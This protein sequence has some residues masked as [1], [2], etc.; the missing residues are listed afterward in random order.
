ML[1]CARDMTEVLF[2]KLHSWLHWA[3][4]EARVIEQIKRLR[5]EGLSITRLVDVGCGPGF[6]YRGARQAE[7]EYIGI[8]PDVKNIEAAR[9]HNP[10][11]QFLF[12]GAESL[13]IPIKASD[14]VLLNGVAHHL[15]DTTFNAFFREVVSCGRLLILDHQKAY[16]SWFNPQFVIQKLDK[17]KFVRDYQFFL[18]LPAQLEHQEM[19]VIRVAGFPLW[20]YFCHCYASLR[21]ESSAG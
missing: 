9:R 19:F 1:Y 8:D 17:G 5:S 2:Y 11:G 20:P 7:I 13:P 18:E 3:E 6:M 12:G 4:R 15:D 16:K 14:L 21:Q 10:E